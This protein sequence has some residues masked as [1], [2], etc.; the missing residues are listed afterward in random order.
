MRS[1]FL[2]PLDVWVF[3]DGR[4]F[5]AGEDHHAKS[6]FPPSP[7]TIQGS[8]RSKVLVENCGNLD[9]YAGRNGNASCPKC[10][11]ESECPLRQEIGTPGNPGP[12][13]LRYVLPAHQTHGSLTTYF[14]LPRHPVSVKGKTSWHF[15]GPQHGPELTGLPAGLRPLGVAGVEPVEHPEGWVDGPTL[16]S[17]LKGEIP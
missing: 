11:S 3:R 14:P 9:K 13:R 8:L 6:V 17:L 5:S 15:L 10:G 4:P 16:Q 12:F 7:F 2:E 1:I